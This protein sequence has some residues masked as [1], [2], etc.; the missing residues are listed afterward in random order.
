MPRARE[1]GTAILGNPLFLGMSHQARLAYLAL[2]VYSDDGGVHEALMPV[3]AGF[4][5]PLKE[6]QTVK[7]IEAELIGNCWITKYEVAGTWYWRVLAWKKPDQPTYLFPLESGQIPETPPRRRVKAVRKVAP[8]K[9]DAPELH[10]DDVKLVDHMLKRITSLNPD[11]KIPEGPARAKWA[12]EFRKMRDIDKR[13]REQI[14]RLIN[15]VY[16]DDFWKSN[17][18]SPAKLRK[19]YD[20][21]IIKAMPTEESSNLAGA[22]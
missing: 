15:W 9:T 20:R 16:K 5:A 21:L 8:R 12:D 10:E 13:D 17:I 6:G 2:M 18:L 1:I 22:R 7:A 4:A 3:L 14:A 11:F 19:Q